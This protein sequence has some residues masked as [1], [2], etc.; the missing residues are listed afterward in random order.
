[1]EKRNHNVDI[2][3][4]IAAMFVMAGHMAYISGG[5]V[6]TFLH[7]Q[8]HAIGVYMLFS[9]GGALIVRSWCN[10]PNPFHYA[11]KRFFRIFP[12]LIVF[13]VLM[14]FVAGPLLSTLPVKDYFLQPG[15]VLYLKNILL[16]PVYTLPGVLGDVPYTWVVNGALWTIPIEIA[17]YCVIPLVVTVSCFRKDSKHMNWILLLFAVTICGLDLWF[18]SLPERPRA[19]IWG[20]DWVQALDVVPFYF[21]G[22]LYASSTVKRFLNIKVALLAVAVAMCLSP[23][24][25]ESHIIL[26]FLIPYCCFSFA[27]AGTV[28]QLGFKKWHDISYG[29]Y[30]YGFFVQQLTVHFSKNVLHQNLS[31]DVLFVFSALITILFAL[32]SDKYIEQP[33]M[34]LCKRLCSKQNKEY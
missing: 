24:L 29:I 5:T 32:L 31:Q 22:M 19:V 6:P 10:D 4:I 21:I 11:C 25:V 30:L 8:I 27:E 23:T 33:V 18:S 14:V 3:R 17:M 28:F 12:P 2:I 26:Y 16:Y 34:R 1:M 13:T 15:T 9:L 20:T 7:V